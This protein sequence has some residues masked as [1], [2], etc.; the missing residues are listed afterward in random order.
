MSWSVRR[1]WRGVGGDVRR[2]GA[3]EL[4]SAAEAYEQRDEYKRA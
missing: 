1:R 4:K 2:F 3:V